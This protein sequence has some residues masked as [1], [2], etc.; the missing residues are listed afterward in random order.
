M[1]T[2]GYYPQSLENPINLLEPKIQTIQSNQ[3]ESY[4][5][6]SNLNQL[7]NV[8]VTI[9]N[10]ENHYYQHEYVYKYVDVKEIHHYHHGIK[11]RGVYNNEFGLQ[12]E[13]E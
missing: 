9:T 7:D 1:K 2:K 5:L 12:D 10:I 4:T 11:E 13:L 3:I 6:C 8:S